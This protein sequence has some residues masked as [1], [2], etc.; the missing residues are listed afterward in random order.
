[1]VGVGLG[2]LW[3]MDIRMNIW[4]IQVGADHTLRGMDECA[5]ELRRS[6]CRQVF[7]EEY[8]KLFEQGFRG[9][10]VYYRDRRVSQH[11]SV[12]SNICNGNSLIQSDLLYLIDR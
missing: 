5:D 3:S 10:G 1:M 11:L 7:G 12:C 8:A 6:L 4:K 9:E 2:H